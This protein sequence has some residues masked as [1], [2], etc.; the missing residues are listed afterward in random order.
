MK[1][2]T[3]SGYKGRLHNSKGFFFNSHFELSVENEI[4][5]KKYQVFLLD[6]ISIKGREIYTIK[7]MKAASN[8]I[9]AFIIPTD[10]TS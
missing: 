10:C 9:L 1:S 4:K 3:S 6:Q 5:R 8:Y 7:N 2:L